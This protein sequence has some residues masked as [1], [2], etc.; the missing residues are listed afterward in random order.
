MSRHPLP[1][2]LPRVLNRRR[3]LE[4]LGAFGTLGLGLVGCGGGDDGDSSASTGSSTTTTTTGSTTTGSTTTGSTSGSGTTTGSTG[5]TTDTAQSCSV[6][7]EETAGPYPADGSN[8]S[9]RSYNV[10][11]LAG[12][13][14]SDI[15]SSIDGSDTATGVPLTLEIQLTSTTNS[16]SPLQGYAIYAWHCTAEGDYSVYTEQN[17]NDNYLRGVQATDA[18]GKVRFTTIVPGCYAGRVPHVHLEIYPSLS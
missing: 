1:A 4:A 10:L 6:V 16:C 15:R 14:R 5:T 12:I 11:A 9:N 13:V 8:A 3:T 2:A 17:V 18:D 7:P